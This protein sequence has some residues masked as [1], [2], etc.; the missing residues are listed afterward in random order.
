MASAAAQAFFDK[1]S[2]KD[3]MAIIDSWGGADL[4]DEWFKNAQAAGSAPAAGAAAPA[5]PTSGAPSEAGIRSAAVGQNEDFARFQSADLERWGPYYD[6]AASQAAGKPQYRSSRGAPG[7]FDKPTECPDGQ[8]PAG[9]DETSP[10]KGNDQLLAAQ[11]VGQAPGAGGAAAGAQGAKP[12]YFGQD[13][14]LQRMLTNQLASG[15]GTFAG[16][17]T[18]G[19]FQGGGVFSQGAGQITPQGPATANPAAT[20]ALAALPGTSS[21][22]APPAPAVSS[23]GVL[24]PVAQS[25]ESSMGLPTQVKA[26]GQDVLG[27]MANGVSSAFGGAGGGSNLV[28][29]A[30][31]QALPALAPGGVKQ[32][33]AFGVAQGSGS[34]EDLINPNRKK[35]DARLGGSWF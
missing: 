19:Q 25:L 26:S 33:D 13:D 27:S 5:A 23:T 8:S 18:G 11:G 10:C 34:F 29:G 30:V 12:A 22:A 28:Q 17:Q 9:P 15:G 2:P 24:G 20:A 4:T 14:P 3:R 1:Q 16:S 6:A 21:I 31:A 35:Q 7:S 32:P